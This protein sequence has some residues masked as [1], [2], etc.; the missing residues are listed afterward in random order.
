MQNNIRNEAIIKRLINEKIIH[1]KDMNKILSGKADSLI[2]KENLIQNGV[3]T[4]N[5]LLYS[6]AF[7]DEKTVINLFTNDKEIITIRL[8]HN[9]LDRVVKF[10]LFYTGH[11]KESVMSLEITD[12]W[13]AFET[14]FNNEF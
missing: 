6:V 1:P 14:Y 10:L 8:L 11:N 9:D 13:W 12:F 4:S 5:Y 3:K 2:E 7:E